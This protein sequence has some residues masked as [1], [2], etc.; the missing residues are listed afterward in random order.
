MKSL[1]L[2]KQIL[3]IAALY[4]GAGSFAMAAPAVP[5]QSSTLG[6]AGLAFAVLICFSLRLKRRVSLP[7]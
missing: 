1:N 6:L 3:P 7:S 5:D 2:L 4:L